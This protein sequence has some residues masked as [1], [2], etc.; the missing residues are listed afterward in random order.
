MDVERT[1]ARGKESMGI[2]GPRASGR[3]RHRED[4]GWG[5][6]GMGG[7]WGGPRTLGGSETTGILGI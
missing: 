2:G 4:M 1:R 3:H 5:T 7:T 6:Q